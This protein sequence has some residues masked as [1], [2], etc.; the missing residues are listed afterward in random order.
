MP[1][2][3]F[4]HIPQSTDAIIDAEHDT[5]Q[6]VFAG[7]NCLSS[8]WRAALVVCLRSFLQSVELTRALIG[9]V[10]SELQHKQNS[11]C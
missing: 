9:S 6:M 4:E 5:C 2:E 1:L 7:D 10:A 8:M 11:R 3:D